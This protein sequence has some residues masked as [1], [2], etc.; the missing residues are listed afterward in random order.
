[1]L[2]EERNHSCY[3]QFQPNMDSIH[4]LHI[5]VSMPAIFGKMFPSV[6]F[7]WLQIM[8][9]RMLLASLGIVHSDYSVPDE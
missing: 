3:M 8:N 6:F 5:P 4:K 1:M 7:L 2:K 9:H